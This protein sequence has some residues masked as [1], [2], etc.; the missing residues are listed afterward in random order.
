MADDASALAAAQTALAVSPF[1][2]GT[3]LLAVP[4]PP[5]ALSRPASYPSQLLRELLMKYSSVL[6][7]FLVAFSR[8]RFDAA[9]RYGSGGAPLGRAVSLHPSL[10]ARLRA[11]AL[12]FRPAVG[13]VLQGRVTQLSD[14][15]VGCLVAGLF[16]ASILLEDMA[17]GY[18]FEEG[19]ARG[20]G[21]EEW[22]GAAA[23]AAAREAEARGGG[24]AGRNPLLA[25]NPTRVRRGESIVFRV[26]GLLHNTGVLT[27]LGSLA[28]EGGGGRRRGGRWGRGQAKGGQAKAR[29]SSR[30]GGVIV[31]ISCVW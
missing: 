4:F 11:E 30:G 12:L 28:A 13:Q 27:I 26:K 20:G 6:G 7:G 15:H 31:I 8:A 21:A 22:V 17:E 19:G 2:G 14:H 25:A 5:S 23:H 1:V 9:G 3:I 24:G 29:V 10:R 16:N 18:V